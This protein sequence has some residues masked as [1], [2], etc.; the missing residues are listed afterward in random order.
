MSTL[1]ITTVGLASHSRVGSLGPWAR[2][3][4]CGPSPSKLPHSVQLWTLHIHERSHLP[5]FQECPGHPTF[6]ALSGWVV[7]GQTQ[8]DDGCDLQDDE[9]HILQ[10]F[11]YQLQEGFWLLWRY[12]VLPKNLF[13]LFQVWS[14]AWQ[15]CGQRAGEL[16]R[17]Q[18]KHTC[19][20][21]VRREQA[22]MAGTFQAFGL[23]A[24]CPKQFM[25][26]V[27]WGGRC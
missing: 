27:G 14:G 22:N 5:V 17:G 8:G 11:P 23:G 10:C 20:W 26:R 2:T 12:E 9:R 24:Q 4:L 13:P 15:T 6:I 3:G 21:E 18:E 19:L 16:G 1:A 7:E 25:S